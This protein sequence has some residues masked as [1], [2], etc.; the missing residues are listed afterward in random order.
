MI[1][2][3]SSL[4]NTMLP[5]EGKRCVQIIQNRLPDQFIGIDGINITGVAGENGLPSDYYFAVLSPQGL[6]LMSFPHKA[7]LSSV[8]ALEILKKQFQESRRKFIDRF[9]THSVLHNEKE[10]LLFP[11]RLLFVFPDVSIE[12]VPADVKSSPFLKK[13]YRFKEWVAI[14]RKIGETEKDFREMMSDSSAPLFSGFDEISEE[15]RDIIINRIAPWATIPKITERD[16][17]VAKKA[18]SANPKLIQ[19]KL[20]KKDSMVQVLRL[21]PKQIDDVNAISKGHQLLL[22]CA[23]SGKSVILIAKCFKLA[24]LDKDRDYLLLCYNRN[25]M[26]YYRWQVDEAGFSK[27]NVKCCTFFQLCEELMNKYSIP[28]PYA[29]NDDEYFTEVVE[30]V[31]LAIQQGV[32]KEKYYGIFIDEVQI[33]APRW[34]RLVYML[35]ENP[36]SDNHILTI[37][38]DMTQNMN[39]SVK[40]GM[41]PWQGEGLPVFRG[42]TIHIEKNYRNSIPINNFVNIYSGLIREKMPK[43]LDLQMNTYLRGTAFREGPDPI[44]LYYHAN[45]LYAAESESVKV[46]QAVQYM[47][48]EQMIGYSEIAVLIYNKAGK[49]SKFPK[50]FPVL[51]RIKHQLLE[52]DIPFNKLSWIE[53]GEYATPYSQREGVS[54]ISFQGSLGLDYKGIIVCAIPLIGAREGICDDTPESI[55]SKTAEVQ[56]EYFRGYDAIYLACTRAKDSLAIVLPDAHTYPCS[57]Y[58]ET[59]RES[60]RLYNMGDNREVKVL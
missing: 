1:L 10:Q 25:L 41:A 57:V 45:N 42:R 24:S 5:P 28:K 6:L 54:L 21:D 17:K 51:N 31:I 32:V 13:N 44:V 36:E 35:L 58:T 9:F 18:A 50:G 46:A 39:K 4:Q 20:G 56:E 34:Y 2:I 60:I 48:D 12:E 55:L 3:P 19:T 27:R 37:C 59:V 52:R 23:G 40:R 7:F 53:K 16:I 8:P 49:Y 14:I 30:R 26:E 15:M 38:G 47:H 33:F 43:N 22:A 11:V 29:K